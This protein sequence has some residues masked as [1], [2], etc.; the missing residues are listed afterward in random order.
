MTG[1]TMPRC[2][3]CGEELVIEMDPD[4]SPDTQEGLLLADPPFRYVC[5]SPGC[6]QPG[7]VE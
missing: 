1:S 4:L 6:S 7:T 3:S 2:P 5:A